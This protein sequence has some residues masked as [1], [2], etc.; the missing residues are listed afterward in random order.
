MIDGELKR[1]I[2]HPLPAIETDELASARGREPS[3]AKSNSR[4]DRPEVVRPVCL[5]AVIPGQRLTSK[6][7]LHSALKE[8]FDPLRTNDSRADFFVVYRKESGEFDRDYAK[9]YDEDLNTSLIFVSRLTSTL[10][11][12]R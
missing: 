10:V 6:S 4:P 12:K 5:T 8:F 1:S 9:K 7:S 3:T 2:S 11:A